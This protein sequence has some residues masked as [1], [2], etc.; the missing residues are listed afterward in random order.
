MTV[1]VFLGPSLPATR[2]SAILDAKY[3]PPVRVGDVCELVVDRQPPEAIAIVDGLFEQTPTVWHKEIL[4]A[5]SRGVRVFGASSMGAI[6]AAEL[7]PFGME[8]VGEVFERFRSGELEDDDEVAV[9]HAPPED[10][11]RPLSEAMVNLRHGIEAA[12]RHGVLRPGT[13]TT[14]LTQA[15]AR[16]YPERS[17]AA[18][19]EIGRRHDLPSAELEGLRRFVHRCAPDIK[20]RD[21]SALLLRLK[22]LVRDGIAPAAPSFDFEPTYN[23]E[24]LVSIVRARRWSAEVARRLRVPAASIHSTLARTRPELVRAALLDFLMAG[25]ARRLGLIDPGDGRALT[26]AT[27]FEPVVRR[28]QLDLCQYLVEHLEERP[29]A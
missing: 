26:A 25:E 11:S 1:H 28:Y 15:K 21:A 13:A 20:G 27:A 6:R 17:W 2:A 7:H 23:W 22:E 19:F 3:H 9:A 5:L 8:G 14:L 18:V 10:G 16:F 12:V 29:D 4:Y 24:K